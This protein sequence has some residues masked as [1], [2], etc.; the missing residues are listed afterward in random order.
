[1]QRDLTSVLENDRIQDTVHILYSHNISGV[2]VVDEEWSLI[3]YIS[4]S[5]ILKAAV[6]TYLE[7]LAQTTFL[8]G[9]E[10]CYLYRRFSAIGHSPVKEYMNRKPVSVG[11]GTGLM[12]VADIMLRR[13]IKRIPVV[14]SGKLVG[15][16]DRE[17]FCEYLMEDAVH[18]ECR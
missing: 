7:V 10:E 3:G 11:L 9:D 14:D 8:D 2:P 16:I 12:S 1:M 6:P 17:S 15:I 4:E 13:G 18:N 5:D